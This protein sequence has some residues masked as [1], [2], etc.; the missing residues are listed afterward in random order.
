M[1]TQLSK[2]M[3][4]L[5]LLVLIMSTFKPQSVLA[6]GPVPVTL[7]APANGIIGNTFDVP[8][9]I[10]DVSNFYGAQFDLLFDSLKITYVSTTWGQIGSTNMQGN[11]TAMSSAITGGRRWLISLNSLEAG[12]SGSGVLG[13]IRFQTVG[14]AGQIATINLANVILSNFAGNAIDAT[15]I[16]DSVSLLGA[17]ASSSPGTQNWYLNSH[18]F[19]VMEKGTG[20]SGAVDIPAKAGGVNG[21][22]TWLANTPAV[23][24]VTFPTGGWTVKLA[25]VDWSNTCSAQIGDW[26]G[27][28]FT[29]F[30][31][32]PANGNYSNG[33]IS[34]TVN[35]G[36]T[37]SK[38]HFLALKIYNGATSVHTI[39][40]DHSSYLS[41][42]TQDPGYPL[43]ELSTVL[44]LGIG[45][46]GLSGFLYVNRKSAVVDEL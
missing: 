38:T 45:L 10:G 9:R 42:P 6:E 28:N 35:A 41:T 12:I 1:Q 5:F 27:M 22:Q 44:L 8:I 31:P 37:V 33:F 17:P 7:D 32:A 19:P 46:V 3:S 16:N 14:T 26:D 20:Q 30:N 24:N 36:G 4:C 40:T 25:T 18:G 43:P 15:W 39:A 11:G 29:A 2:L 21:F 13:T 23:A 34:I